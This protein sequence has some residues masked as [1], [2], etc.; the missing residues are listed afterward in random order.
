MLQLDR[1]LEPGE[2]SSECAGIQMENR[3]TI[4]KK[5]ATWRPPVKHFAERCKIGI[6]SA[7]ALSILI[8]IGDYTALLRGMPKPNKA[9]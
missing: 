9:A 8:K 1:G 6:Q 4:L 2:I 3:W 7:R 5:Y